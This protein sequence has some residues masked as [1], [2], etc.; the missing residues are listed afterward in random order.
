M[1]IINSNTVALNPAFWSNMLQVPLRKSLVSEAVANTQFEAKLAYGTSI[2]QPFIDET[3]SEA[4]VPGTEFV[5]KGTIATQDSLNVNTY[6]IVPNYVDD[7]N[8]LQS[9]YR[10][11]MDIIDNQA[12]QLKDDID[13]DVFAQTTSAGNFLFATGATPGTIAP[14]TT[15]LATAVSAIRLHPLATT[16]AACSPIELFSRVRRELRAQNVSEAGDWVAVVSPEVAQ[17]VEM[18]GADKGF[19]VADSTLRNGWAGNFL[20]FKIYVSNNLPPEWNYF[21]KAKC[22]DLVVQ[23]PPRVV[24]KD[25]SNRLGTNIVSSV[26]YG[27]N[28]FTRN[29]QRFLGVR[30]RAL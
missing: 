25:V 23:M 6:R 3:S 18:I 17:I 21:G 20:G 24:F 26:V 2:N 7:I 28:T 27:V 16:T 10:Y 15:T 5:A 29:K 12:F 4:Y 14:K 22:I 9:K 30:A 13:R 1:A 8:E 19:S 11:A